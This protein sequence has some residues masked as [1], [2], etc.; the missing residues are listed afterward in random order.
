M[1]FTGQEDHSITFEEGAV[2]TQNYRDK[3]PIGVRKGGYFGMD[4]IQSLLDE[5][6]CVG[7]RYYYGLDKDD[8][9]VLVLVGVD[10]DENDIISE[11]ALCIEASVPCPPYCGNENILNS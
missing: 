10:E 3:M 7:I 8:K 9:Q 11:R 5:E 2:L 1:A 6:G 4:A